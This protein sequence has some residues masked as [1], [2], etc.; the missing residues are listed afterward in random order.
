M[1]SLGFTEI[2]VVFL[3][4]LLVLGPQQFPIVAKNFIKFLNEL[5]QAFTEMKSNFDEVKTDLKKPIQQITDDVEKSLEEK[6][7]TH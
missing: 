2:L 5:R 4:A 7:N 3:I 6:D 1:F